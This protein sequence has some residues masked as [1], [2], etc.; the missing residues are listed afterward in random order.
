MVTARLHGN[1]CAL[2]PIAIACVFRELTL[3]FNTMHAYFIAHCTV[4]GQH[5]VLVHVLNV[6]YGHLIL[7]VKS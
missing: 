1:L 5:T 7:A 3:L 2:V 4:Y 6:V